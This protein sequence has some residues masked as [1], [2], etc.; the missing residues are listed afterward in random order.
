MLRL[1]L[2]RQLQWMVFEPNSPRLRLVLTGVVTQLLRELYRAGAFA[3]ASEDEA[4]FVRC[5]EALNPAWSQQLGRVVA[6]IGVA[7]AQPLEYLV[8]RISQDADGTLSVDGPL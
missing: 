4:F 2:D 8:L 1:V 3:G 7:P 5:D 6:E